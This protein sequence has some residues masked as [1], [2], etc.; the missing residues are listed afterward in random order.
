[1]SEADEI[2]T[3]ANALSR[4]R[5]AAKHPRLQGSRA[6]PVSL[7]SGAA[8]SP[9]TGA[10][11]RDPRPREGFQLLARLSGAGADRQGVHDGGCSQGQ[12]RRV[13]LGP[14]FA[15]LHGQLQAVGDSAVESLQTAA[16]DVPHGGAA[17]KDSSVRGVNLMRVRD[18]RIVEAFGYVKGP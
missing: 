16:Q 11:Q 5:D 9:W 10:N 6:G 12:R 13:R 1:M 14:K 17:H 2:P 8:T 4:Q 18:G 3:N 15:A 7:I